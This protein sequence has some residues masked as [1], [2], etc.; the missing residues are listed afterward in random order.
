MNF[1]HRAFAWA[2]VASAH[3][4]LVAAV[5]QTVPPPEP[6]TTVRSHE[7]STEDY[8]RHLVALEVLVETCAKARD[9]KGC[10]PALVGP[11]DKITIVAGGKTELRLIRYGW[12]RLLLSKAEE[13]DEQPSVAS[14]SG[15]GHS[16][17]NPAEVTTSKLLETARTRLEHDLAESHQPSLPAPDYARERAVMQEVLSGRDFRSAQQAT[18]TDSILEKVGNWLNHI[19]ASVANLRTHSVWVGRI[20]VWGFVLG[21]CIALAYALLKLERRWRVRL[22]PEVEQRPAPGA[23]SARAWQLWLE[24][25]RKA[26]AAG[27]WREAIHFLYWAAI[28][29]LESRRLW[30]ADRARTPREYLALVAQ[31]DPRRSRL[32][33]LTWTFERFWYGGR[34]AGE[35]DYRAA[36]SLATDL[37]NGGTHEGG[38]Q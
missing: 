10:D 6:Q 36:E 28:S 12:L 31:E 16:I 13:P 9:A 24:D 1:V 19:F 29:R 32:S 8:R 17:A 35:N 30:P 18:T 20:I 3:C 38:V 27:A 34:V 23:A 15:K 33:Q 14:K 37:I 5:P 4:A 26:A 25:A 2:L 11:D 21:V 7:V 22:T